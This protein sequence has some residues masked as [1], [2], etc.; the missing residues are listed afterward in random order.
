MA[1]RQSVHGELPFNQAI[2][3]STHGRIFADQ[4]VQYIP[5]ILGYHNHAIFI[6]LTCCDSRVDY[7]I[8]DACVTVVYGY[9]S[10]GRTNEVLGVWDLIYFLRLRTFLCAS[11]GMLPLELLRLQIWVSYPTG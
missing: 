11:P 3:G 2:I 8:G 7:P 1:F 6:T 4:F 9:G 10:S 5:L